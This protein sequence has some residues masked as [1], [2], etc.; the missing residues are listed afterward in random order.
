MGALDKEVQAKLAAKWNQDKADEARAWVEAITGKSFTGSDKDAWVASLKDGELLCTLINA[1]KSGSAKYK[2]STMA[3]GQRENITQYLDGC[4][5][6]GQKDVDLFVTQDLYEG[7]NLVLVVDQ[8]HA[9]GSLSKTI[10]GFKGP[11]IGVKHAAEN[12]RTFSPEVLVAGAMATPLQNSGSIA[13]E[14]ERGTDHIVRYGL[15][16]NP[17][18]E[19]QARAGSAAVPL[20]NS[21]SIQVTKENKTDAIVRYATAGDPVSAEQARAGSAVI[22]L[23]NQGAVEPEKQKAQDSLTRALHS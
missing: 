7:D 4:R 5:K 19:E 21:G 8:L 17:V 6:L 14:K 10:E 18:S 20:G 22:P 15:S 13:V 3:F 9:L 23:H 12:K 2:A 1:I 16:E 11:Y